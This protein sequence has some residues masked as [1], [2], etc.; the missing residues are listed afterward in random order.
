MSA[1]TNEQRCVYLDLFWVVRNLYLIWI[2]LLNTNKMFIICITYKKFNGNQRVSMN[3]S[4]NINNSL[5]SNNL[6][7]PVS[8]RVTT[9][10]QIQNSKLKPF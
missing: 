3:E 7:Y 6:D 10:P 1:K 4:I 2:F 5:Y 9:L 8:G